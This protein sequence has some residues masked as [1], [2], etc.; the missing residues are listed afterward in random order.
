MQEEY[1]IQIETPEGWR[2]VHYLFSSASL[3]E[4][5]AQAMHLTHGCRV[6]VVRV[7]FHPLGGGAPAQR[8]PVKASPSQDSGWDTNRGEFVKFLIKNG[9]LTEEMQG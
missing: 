1:R 9:M 2:A 6:R 8:I 3:A 4:Q 7:E 5:G